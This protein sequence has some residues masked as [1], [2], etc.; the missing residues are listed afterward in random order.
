VWRCVSALPTA[1]IVASGSLSAFLAD[2]QSAAI[3]ES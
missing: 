2:Y 3:A 1:V